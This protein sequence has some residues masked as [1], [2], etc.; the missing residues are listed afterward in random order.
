MQRLKVEKDAGT[1]TVRFHNP[2]HHYMDR[3]TATALEAL[4]DDVQASDEVR[5]VILTGSEPGLFIR[6]YDVSEL[7]QL[8]KE[9]AE[10]GAQFSIDNPSPE[11]VV[12]RCYRRM[13]EL[14]VPFI[15]AINGHAMGGGFEM[16][17]ACDIRLVQDG[18]FDLGLPEVNIGILPGAGGTQRLPRLIGQSRA[19]QMMLLGNTITPRQAVDYG[20]AMECV[21]GDVQHRAKEI[22][23][24]IATLPPN[25]LAHIKHLVRS[26]AD[27]SLQD[28]LA[29]ERTL[30]MDLM[31]SN[32][33]LERMQNMVDGGDIRNTH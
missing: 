22:A 13:E 2:P 4:L 15:A 26:A 9:L 6:H 33:G 24:Q 17:L 12:H 16:A 30:F 10:Q 19:L 8:A 32:D 3:H 18:E 7:L 11:A 5:V 1:W 25:A 20:I 14:P 23:S 28:G 21:D 31:V 27:Y 29:R